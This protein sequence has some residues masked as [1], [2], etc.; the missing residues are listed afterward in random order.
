LVFLVTICIFSWTEAVFKATHFVWTVFYIIAM[1]YPPRKASSAKLAAVQPTEQRAEDAA[2][3]QPHPASGGASP[4]A[5]AS[6]AQPT[7]LTGGRS[8]PP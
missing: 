8:S 4:G 1:D 6:V 2:P 5:A 3:T 7:L